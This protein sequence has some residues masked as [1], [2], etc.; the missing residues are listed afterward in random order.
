MKMKE[1]RLEPTI[2]PSKIVDLNLDHRAKK[3]TDRDK[4]CKLVVYRIGQAG[5]GVLPLVVLQQSPEYT[6]WRMKHPRDLLPQFQDLGVGVSLNGT[7]FGARVIG[8]VLGFDWEDEGD[9]KAR[10]RLRQSGYRGYYKHNMWGIAWKDNG[11]AGIEFK[12]IRDN[13]A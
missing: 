1:R 4:Q 13:D 10:N 9:N 7:Y 6:D 12:V 2:L 8:P 5:S 3:T 11:A